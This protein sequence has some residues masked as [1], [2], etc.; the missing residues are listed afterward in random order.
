MTAA[1]AHLPGVPVLQ[2]VSKN[3]H[4]SARHMC[5]K[6][7]LATL[8]FTSTDLEGLGGERVKLSETNQ[9][10]FRCYASF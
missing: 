4:L 3:W 10:S 9:E 2:V 5:A 7:K 1:R 6:A 8:L